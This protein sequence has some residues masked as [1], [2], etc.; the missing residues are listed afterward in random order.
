MSLNPESTPQPRSLSNEDLDFIALASSRLH[1]I[2]Q[3]ILL[4]NKLEPS[5]P[6]EPMPDLKIR[7]DCL[8]QSLDRAAAE[9]T[10]LRGIFYRLVADG[11][12]GRTEQDFYAVK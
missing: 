6:W 12:I 1:Q 3:G 7:I 4:N 5:L 2:S 11:V 8:R 10:T 9:P